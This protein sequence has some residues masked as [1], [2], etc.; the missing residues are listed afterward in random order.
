MI[1][2]KILINQWLAFLTRKLRNNFYL[3]LSALLTVFVLLDA[4]VF[5]GFD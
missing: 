1:K 5:H 4:S 3:Y 2:L